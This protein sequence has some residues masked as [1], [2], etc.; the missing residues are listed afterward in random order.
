MGREVLTLGLF[1]FGA[2]FSD[3]LRGFGGFLNRGDACV[4]VL[5]DYVNPNEDQS[6]GVTPV[7]N[8]AAMVTKAPTPLATTDEE[9]RSSNL[10]RPSSCGDAGALMGPSAW[11]PPARVRGMRPS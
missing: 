11:F 1:E 8:Q 9:G 4:A 6:D 5:L 3:S 7:L 2:Q 10:E